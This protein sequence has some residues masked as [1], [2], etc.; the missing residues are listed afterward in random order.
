MRIAL[1]DLGLHHLWVVYPGD[2]AYPAD[3]RVTMW[4][5]RDVARLAEQLA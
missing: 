4:P 2:A 3:E 1:K 5:M